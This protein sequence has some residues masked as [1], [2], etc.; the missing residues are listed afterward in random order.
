[1]C[2]DSSFL[3][4]WRDNVDASSLSAYI[5]YF[6]LQQGRTVI[7]EQSFGSPKVTKD[8]VTVAKAI[9]FKD[10]LKN[11]GASLVKSVAN[12]TNDVAGDGNTRSQLLESSL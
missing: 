2:L 5:C 1:M 6:S 12:S 10:R 9:E 4:Y 3:I 11:V 8:G 7:I